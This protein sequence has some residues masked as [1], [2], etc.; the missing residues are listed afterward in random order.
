[1][2]TWRTVACTITEEEAVK[3]DAEVARIRAGDP[4]AMA[5]PMAPALIRGRYLR[6]GLLAGRM[7]KLPDGTAPITYTVA[8]S[9]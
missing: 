1:M 2:T 6:Y 5:H 4:E 8:A 3:L 9:R 7:E